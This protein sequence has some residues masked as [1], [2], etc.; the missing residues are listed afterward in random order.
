[1]SVSY[2]YGYGSSSTDIYEGLLGGI[3]AA[4]GIVMLLT[5]ILSILLIISQWK[6]FTKFNKPGWYALIPFLN[7]W[8]FF[9]IVGI[10]GWWSLIPGANA[11]FNLI[12]YYK[13][14]KLYGK[15]NG[16][17]IGTVLLPF[18][19]LPILAFSKDSEKQ[20]EENTI[21]A[22]Y[23]TFNN[24]SNNSMQN[25]QPFTQTTNMI[26]QQPI[27]NNL[28]NT[29]T[30]QINTYMQQPQSVNTMNQTTQQVSSNYNNQFINNQFVKEP[31]MNNQNVS[32]PKMN[33][34]V[35]PNSAVNNNQFVNT[36]QT[37]TNQSSPTFKV[38]QKCGNK[39][40]SDSNNCFMCGT[41][42]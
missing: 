34:N 12:S 22:N 4:L 23:N 21:Q 26:N 13:I 18:I 32:T 8:T 36:S 39:V 14:A 24:N 35:N 42:L 9:E 38:C 10:H 19:F 17:A 6:I 3:M 29:A 2:N 25:T 28:A 11:I 40:S 30:T 1:M 33:T 37:N 31:T 16:F 15:S 5:S 7:I 41:Q 20:P 27:Q